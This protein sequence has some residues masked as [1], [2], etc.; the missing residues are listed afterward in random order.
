[1]INYD[2][3]KARGLFI[4][5]LQQDDLFAGYRSENRSCIVRQ[6]PD[7]FTAGDRH[8]NRQHSDNRNNSFN[9]HLLPFQ[10][11]KFLFQLHGF[12]QRHKPNDRSFYVQVGRSDKGYA[13][14]RPGFS[15]RRGLKLLIDISCIWLLS[16]SVSAGSGPEF[17]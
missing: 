2:L 9:K 16:V 7:S 13:L 4:G 3:R 15:N 1:M 10:I 8:K 6:G 5:P 11:S 17:R 12:L 14:K